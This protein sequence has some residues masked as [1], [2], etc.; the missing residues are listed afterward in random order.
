MVVIEDLD[1][2]DDPTSSSSSSSTSDP[3]APTIK[4]GFLNDDNRDS[5][6]GPD[7]S[8][9]GK[10][11]EKQKQQWA[12][13]DMNREQNKKAGLGGYSSSYDKPGWFTTD[14]PSNCQYNNPDCEVAEMD[15]TTHESD[16]HREVVRKSDRWRVSVLENTSN[17]VRLSFLGMRDED[18]DAMVEELRD[19]EHI[20]HIDLTF[21]H[22]KDAGIQRLVGSL[23]NKKC[24]PGLKTLRVY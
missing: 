7:G 1:E 3:K 8:E 21:N 24:L 2:I 14:W 11:T 4:K 6:Y 13:D 9:Q 20:E 18:L 16:L 12:V 19:R 17:E 5:L 23:A 22:L 15:T 10:V